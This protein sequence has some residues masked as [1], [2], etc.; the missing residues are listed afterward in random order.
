MS[1]DSWPLG[2]LARKKP[3]PKTIWDQREGEVLCCRK[4]LQQSL[5]LAKMEC[6]SHCKV[7]S[8]DLL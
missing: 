1:L 7:M 3:K 2:E 5:F 8:Q 6:P 4:Q